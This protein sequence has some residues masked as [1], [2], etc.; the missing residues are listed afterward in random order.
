M[1]LPIVIIV[2]KVGLTKKVKFEQ[3]PEDLKER[4]VRTQIC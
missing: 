1:G 2:V 3:R 4:R